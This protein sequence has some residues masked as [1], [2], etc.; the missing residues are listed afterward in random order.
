[1]QDGAFNLLTFCGNV[2]HWHTDGLQCLIVDLPV[3]RTDIAERRVE[4]KAAE[5]LAVLCV[6]KAVTC[7]NA[8]GS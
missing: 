2:L 4:T 1:M 7:A 5:Q 3:F 8:C 6:V